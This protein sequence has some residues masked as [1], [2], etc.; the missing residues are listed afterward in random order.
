MKRRYMA[1]F[2][3]VV[4]L[5]LAAWLILRPMPDNRKDC[6]TTTTEA[7][8][9]ESSPTTKPTSSSTGSTNPTTEST[10]STQP[11]TQQTTPATESTDPPTTPPTAPPTQ[12][13]T[14]P[15]ESTS[16]PTVPPTTQPTVPPTVPPT[17]S[18]V[19]EDYTLK[20][21]QPSLSLEVGQIGNLTVNYTG[22]GTI[23]WKSSDETKAT[24]S[25]GKVTAK[26]EGPVTITVTDGVK[27]SQCQVTITKKA[28]TSV[29]VT[30]KLSH[31]N[32]DLKVG[33]SKNLSVSYNGNKSLT[34][35]SSNSSVA[36][37]KNGKVTA[38]SAGTP[39]IITV[40]D[41]VNS[42]QCRVTVTNNS[43][44]AEATLRLS[45]SSLNLVV[46]NTSTLTATYNGTGTLT[47]SSSNPS[48]ATVS[49]GKIT[50]KA[51]TEQVIISVT[52]G[53]L[54]AQCRVTITAPATQTLKINTKSFTTIYV[55]DTLQIDY[56]YSGDKSKLTWSSDDTSKLTVNSKGVV[57]GK[58]AGTAGVIISDGN[59]TRVVL[60][61]VSD[62]PKATKLEKMS[63]NAP[64]YDGVIKYAGDYMTFEVYAMPE[65]SNRQCVV[66][67]SNSSVVSVSYDYDYSNITQ[68]TLNFKR[69]GNAKVTIISADGNVSE[70]YNIT[71]KADYA[72]NPGSGIL[73][74]EQFVNAYNGVVN[75]NGMDTSYVVSGYLVLTLSE[76]DLT[77][78]TARRHAEG[79]FH[80]WYSVRLKDLCLTYE[81]TNADGK[82]VFYVHR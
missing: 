1:I 48:A 41:G 4:I 29:K 23:V 32:L 66:T 55:G 16:P 44:P 82:H 8:G 37:D 61:T 58:A 30:L 6:T 2:I 64:L 47:W 39:A 76:L 40:T 49:N 68:V 72:C 74:P 78:S 45:A 56:T 28:E 34:W 80:H 33:E 69:A 70:S 19:P 42:A 21:S 57:T 38:K 71:V 63:F 13:I 35:T 60:I 73:T 5:L 36:V 9:Q 20:I 17:E 7:T 24:V 50:A 26:S 10:A 75:A 25:N 79:D 77:W 51:A 53:T 11:S 62:A 27:S 31:S 54:T 22:T 52:D 12:Q 3:A 67:S 81:G 15:T 65:E 59:I 46:G 43:K 14:P 18:T